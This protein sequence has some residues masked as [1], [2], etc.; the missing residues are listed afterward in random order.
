MKKKNYR[1]RFG[2]MEFSYDTH[3]IYITPLIAIDWWNDGDTRLWIGWLNFGV[4]F[5]LKKASQKEQ[6]DG[7]K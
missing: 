4:Y 6:S 3:G 2:R 1:K 5:F 7:I